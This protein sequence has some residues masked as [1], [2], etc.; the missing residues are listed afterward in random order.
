MRAVVDSSSWISMARAGLLEVLRAA[1]VEPVLLD[2]VHA[3]IIDEGRRGG[4][5][6]SAALSTAVGEIALTA[7]GRGTASA[8]AGVL[9]VAQQVGLLVANDLALGRRAR[10]LGV[11]WIRTA[12]LVVIAVRNGAMTSGDGTEALRA[13]VTS[14]RITRELAEA[15]EGQLQ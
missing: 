10:S 6:D 14:G 11:V 15:Y 12:D 1:A 3:E 5:A 9:E 7:T 4:H 13:L 8:D 2:I